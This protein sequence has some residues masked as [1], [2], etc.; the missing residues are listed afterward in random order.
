MGSDNDL[1]ANRIGDVRYLSMLVENSSLGY[2]SSLD[3][4]TNRATKPTQHFCATNFLAVSLRRN[5][6]R[7]L[8]AYLLG[9]VHAQGTL[10]YEVAVDTQFGVG[11]FRSFITRLQDFPVR[12]HVAWFPTADDFV[13]MEVVSLASKRDNKTQYN[14]Q[15]QEADRDCRFTVGGTRCLQL[16]VTQ[17]FRLG[18]TDRQVGHKQ[19]AG[20]RDLELRLRWLLLLAWLQCF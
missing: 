14:F 11:N 12:Q 6:H 7:R 16:F 4:T 9:C 17:L 5:Y 13:W 15:S 19:R 1:L 10:G 2:P 20:S 3:Q 18:R 8:F